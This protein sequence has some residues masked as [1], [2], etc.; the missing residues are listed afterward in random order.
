M[1][2]GCRRKSSSSR[3]HQRFV[4]VRQ[5]PSGRWVA[6]IKDSL[7]KVRLWL[8]TFDTAEDAARAYDDA[9]RALR[10]ANARTNFELP[11]A[12]SHHH[13]QYHAN[14]EP[15]SFEQVSAG[16]ASTGVET[17]GLLGA[18]KAKL[19]DGDAKPTRASL[20]FPLRA[21]P[22]V[23]QQYHQNHHKM[24][25]STTSPSPSHDH[26]D[27]IVL[28]DHDLVGLGVHHQLPAATSTSLVWSNNEAQPSYPDQVLP[29]II[30]HNNIHMNVNAASSGDHW[31]LLSAAATK[32]SVSLNYTSNNNSSINP[33]EIMVHPITSFNNNNDDI[34]GTHQG[35]CYCSLSHDQQFVVYDNNVT[36]AL[37]GG[38][39][40]NSIT[41]ST[42]GPWDPLFYM[43]SVLG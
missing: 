24:T 7:Q 3:G 37:L 1:T 40:T 21:K 5:R 14:L 33:D 15:F 17:E 38:S 13:N 39:S 19:F 32:T 43:S 10:G 12:A 9:A 23:P 18:L 11:A 26:H 16:S 41:T 29:S 22:L 35:L 36:A 30:N 8:G 25:T 28:R 20:L 2:S 6:E 34:S 27:V 31:P 4:G 42:T